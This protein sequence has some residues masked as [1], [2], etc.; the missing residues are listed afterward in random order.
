[1]A[2]VPTYSAVYTPTNNRYFFMPDFRDNQAYFPDN[3]NDLKV[4][5]SNGKNAAYPGEWCSNTIFGGDVAALKN[6]IKYGG[7]TNVN[8]LNIGSAVLTEEAATQ[9]VYNLGTPVYQCINK[10]TPFSG[11]ELFGQDEESDSPAT[12]EISH[13]GGDTYIDWIYNGEIL[14]TDTIVG[15]TPDKVVIAITNDNTSINKY[16]FIWAEEFVGPMPAGQTAEPT[17]YTSGNKSN[18]QVIQK[19]LNNAGS[20]DAGIEVRGWSDDE[21]GDFILSTIDDYG[22][23]YGWVLDFGDIPDG[24][25]YAVTNEVVQKIVNEHNDIIGTDVVS[26]LAG[27][28]DQAEAWNKFNN[29]PDYANF[30]WTLPVSDISGLDSS[31]LIWVQADH[32]WYVQVNEDPATALFVSYPSAARNAPA[33]VWLTIWSDGQSGVAEEI[34]LVVGQTIG[35]SKPAYRIFR[36]NTLDVD[37]FLDTEEFDYNQIALEAMNGLD[38]SAGQQDDPPKDADDMDDPSVDA[39]ASGFIYAFGVTPN[40]MQNLHSA[41]NHDTLAAKIK[42]DFGNHLFD[43]IVSYHTM[44]CVTNADVLNKV[45]IQ[46]RGIDFIYGD[47]DTPLTLAQITKSFYKVDLGEKL[48]LPTGVRADGFENWSQAQIQLYLPFIGTHHLNTADVWGK[49]VHVVYYFD[50]LAGTCTA[51]VS[52]TGKGTIYTFESSCSYKIP[53]TSTIDQSLQNMMAGIMSAGSSLVGTVAAAST[54]NVAGTITSAMSG[55]G[56]IGSFISAAEHKS[57]IS[58][59]GQLGGSAGWHCSR[60]PVLIITVPDKAEISLTD[61]LKLNGYPTHKSTYL[62]QY[63]GTYV[64]VGQIN[65]KAAANSEGAIPND[66]ELDM[67]KSALKEGV[68]V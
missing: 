33:H 41:L 13:N 68:Y 47:A 15:H 20:S 31:K 25:T 14:H 12:L 64:E 5:Q 50:V 58:R 11:G 3:N 30:E 7:T 35:G 38:D 23:S 51:N 65:L 49:Y 54:G 66:D 42:D 67:I 24:A 62:S 39:L 17:I 46:Y 4:L 59:G 63:A 53:F 6:Y 43:F 19:I 16:A 61:Y 57:I 32:M 27:T 21:M 45:G 37:D 10:C 44:P 28:D 52:I 55:A 36:L 18:A 56:A 29:D 8:P 40:D 2:T 48:C 26:Y 60:Q 34:G 22:S 1:M 9:L